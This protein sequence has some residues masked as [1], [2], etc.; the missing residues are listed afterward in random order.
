[1]TKLTRRG[2]LA[3]GIGGLVGGKD[4]AKSVMDIP[5]QST[6]IPMPGGYPQEVAYDSPNMLQEKI[7]THRSY[8]EKIARGELQQWQ[9][10]NLNN[11]SELRNKKLLH[12]IDGLKS[13]SNSAK[14]IML[15]RKGK[16][17]TRQDWID[18]AKKDLA[19]MAKQ[20]IFGGNKVGRG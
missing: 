8:L 15:D 10:D 5:M 17:R 11:Y 19:E 9:E 7:G 1:M 16:E 20:S 18:Q 2:I 13:M 14:L 12:E 4:A 6:G 3:A